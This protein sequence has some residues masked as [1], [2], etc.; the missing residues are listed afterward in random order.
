V[1]GKNRT[2]ATIRFSFAA[3]R[4][5]V[6]KA[7]LYAIGNP[8][9]I[10]IMI[11]TDNTTLYIQKCMERTRNRIAV[12]HRVYSDGVAVFGFQKISFAEAIRKRLGW[13]AKGVY[14]IHGVSVADDIM[15]FQF[16]MAERIDEGRV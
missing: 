14:R 10:Q 5:H 9:Y 15:A 11:A 16:S 8:A 12:P 13:D 4:I 3:N 2:D 1:K 7:V 6:S